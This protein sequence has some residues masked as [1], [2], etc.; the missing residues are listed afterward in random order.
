MTRRL[1]PP[2]KAVEERML[3]VGAINPAW[4]AFG[5]AKNQTA[6]AGFDLPQEPVIVR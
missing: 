1:R 3:Y 6:A 5:Y 2:L 4:L